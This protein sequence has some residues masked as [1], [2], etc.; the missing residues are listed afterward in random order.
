MRGVTITDSTQ[1]GLFLATDLIDILRLLGA[2]ALEAEWEITGVECVGA[3]A[4]DEL[5]QLGEAKGKVPGGTLLKLAAE[6]IQ[7]VDG[8]FTGYRHGE[9]HPWVVIRAVDS[10]AYDVESDDE[11]VLARMRQQFQNVAELPSDAQPL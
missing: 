6:I 8:T 5:H 7:V 11:A 3:A 4:A 2:Q 1:D 9:T 10:S